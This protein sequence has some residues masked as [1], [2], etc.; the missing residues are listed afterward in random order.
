MLMLTK[1]LGVI[2][3]VYSFRTKGSFCP[4]R[5]RKASPLHSGGED[6]T[7]KCLRLSSMDKMDGTQ[8]QVFQPL[9]YRKHCQ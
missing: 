7:R 2:F 6:E 1:E 4:I 5:F 3:Y 9:T 8:R